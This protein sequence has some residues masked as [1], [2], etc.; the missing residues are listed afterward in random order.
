MYTNINTDECLDRLTEFLLRLSMETRFPHYPA[1]ALVKA[2]HLIMKNNRLR[3]GDIIVQQLKGIAMG[4]SPAPAIANQFGVIYKTDDI[5]P[6]FKKY[7]P[8]LSKIYQ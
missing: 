6:A 3:F 1:K 4:M 2:L 8:S 7:L 5:L